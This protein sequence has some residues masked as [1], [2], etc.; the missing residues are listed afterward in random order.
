MPNKTGITESQITQF[1][2]Q[3]LI[4]FSPYF[5]FTL[6]QGQ[7]QAFA[8]VSGTIAVFAFNQRRKQ[9]KDEANVS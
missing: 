1:V 4:I 7:M 3:L 2:L 8:G 9:K 6:T 5:A